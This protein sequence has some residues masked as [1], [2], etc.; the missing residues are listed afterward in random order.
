MSN[1]DKRLERL[2]ARIDRA[3]EQIEVIL[4]RDGE[5]AREVWA[6]DHPGEAYPA[7]AFVVRFVSPMPDGPYGRA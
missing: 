7:N 5:S 4:T 2:E 1:I 6:R 3:A